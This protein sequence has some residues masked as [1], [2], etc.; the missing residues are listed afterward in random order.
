MI[1]ICHQDVSNLFHEDLLVTALAVQL[2]FVLCQSGWSQTFLNSPRS[3]NRVSRKCQRYHHDQRIGLLGLALVWLP[4]KCC[5]GRRPCGKESCLP[6][7]PALRDRLS[8]WEERSS[9]NYTKKSLVT[10]TSHI[11]IWIV[12]TFPASWTLGSCRSCAPFWLGRRLEDGFRGLLQCG[13]SRGWLWYSFT[14]T[15]SS[16]SLLV[17][18]TLCSHNSHKNYFCT[19]TLQI[20]IHKD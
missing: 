17:T 19:L 15:A 18:C 3:Q 4:C 13:H 16:D 6:P 5:S 2:C 9:E 20:I 1:H 8:S 12:W 7:S 14:Q 11:S 10:A